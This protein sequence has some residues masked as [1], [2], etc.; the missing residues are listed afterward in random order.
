MKLYVVELHHKD[1]RVT[2]ASE[3]GWWYE[4]EPERVFTSVKS[5]RGCAV[6]WK[7]KH[8]LG[9]VKLTA[10]HIREAAIRLHKRVAESIEL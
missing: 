7:R 6:N 8:G 2:Y 5:A 9:E 10:I 4:N 3:V 1:G